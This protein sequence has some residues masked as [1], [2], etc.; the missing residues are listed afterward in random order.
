MPSFLDEL[1]AGAHRR[2][3]EASRAVPLEALI[4][5]ASITPQPASFAAALAGEGVAVIAEIKRASPSRGAIDL[6][7][8]ASAVAMAYRDAGAAA[9]S[10][11]TEPDGFRGSLDDL[12]EVAKLGVP[13][14]RKDFIVDPYQIWEAKLAGAAAVLL[15]VAALSDAQLRSLMAQAATAGLDVLVEAHD[16]HEVDAA[17]MAGATIVG[18]NARDLRTFTIDRAAFGRLRSRLPAGVIAVAESGVRDADD[19]ERHAAE[20]ADAVLVGESLVSAE[21]PGAALAALVAAGRGQQ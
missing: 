18:I 15:I 21:D 20:G 16:D 5:Q 10:V 7:L 17:V 11:L 19:V 9:I 12:T 3:A 4:E 6:D 13:S 8:D 14:L 2:V 1:V